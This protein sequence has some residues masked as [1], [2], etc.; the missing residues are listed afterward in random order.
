MDLENDMKDPFSS[1]GLWKL[2]NFTL[3]SLQPLE[4]LQPDEGLPGELPFW[5][6]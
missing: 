2:S 3:Q 4:S 6:I 5:N 1:D